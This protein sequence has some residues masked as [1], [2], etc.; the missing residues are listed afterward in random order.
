F[1]HELA[2]TPTSLAQVLRATGFTVLSV[3][4]KLPTPRTTGG[5]GRKLFFQVLDIIGRFIIAARHGRRVTD[6]VVDWDTTLPDLLARAKREH[7]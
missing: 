1:T 4:G 6:G 7:G 3:Q 2:V 5:L